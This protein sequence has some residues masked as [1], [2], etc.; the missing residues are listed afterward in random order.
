MNNVSFTKN[1][2]YSGVCSVVPH[3]CLFNI[4]V[5]TI[6]YLNVSTELLLK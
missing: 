6:K 2:S 5:Y 4:S 1:K 3:F